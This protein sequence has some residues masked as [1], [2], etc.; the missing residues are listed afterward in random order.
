MYR[1]PEQDALDTGAVRE[2]GEP[3]ENRSLKQFATERSAKD[4]LCKADNGAVK[5]KWLISLGAAKWPG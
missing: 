3:E 2:S 4:I 1:G 5:A